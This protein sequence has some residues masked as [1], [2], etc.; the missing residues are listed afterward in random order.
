MNI[1]RTKLDK[2]TYVDNSKNDDCIG[3][4]EV[5]I[6]QN[7]DLQQPMND[8]SQAGQFPVSAHG[9]SIDSGLFLATGYDNLA[10]LNEAN[11]VK[12][13]FDSLDEAYDF[14]VYYARSVGFGVCKG[15]TSLN[16][17]RVVTRRVFF[18]Q[19]GWSKT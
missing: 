18:L 2:R 7:T 3:F 12:K 6:S 8:T 11:I 13:E 17:S 9:E 14:Y 10:D 19:Q 15:D 5:D 4:E 16:R 1:D